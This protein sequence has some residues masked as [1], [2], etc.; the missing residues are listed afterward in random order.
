MTGISL[1]N[2]R[3]KSDDSVEKATVPSPRHTVTS[4]T[5]KPGPISPSR[6]ESISAY[7]LSSIAALTSLF[8]SF[9]PRPSTTSDSARADA[10]A[11]AR[12][13]TSCGAR[14]AATVPTTATSAATIQAARAFADP[15]EVFAMGT[16]GPSDP[17]T[18]RHNPP[19]DQSPPA[20]PLAPHPPAGVGPPC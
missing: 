8:S 12:P 1:G 19:I 5:G 13:R 15:V 11:K 18:Y 20:W 4:S 10:V 17:Y 16:Q 2:R 14:K 9:E 3:C 6:Y 7:R